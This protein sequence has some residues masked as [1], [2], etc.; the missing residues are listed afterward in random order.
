[1]KLTGPMTVR[2]KGPLKEKLT[3]PMTV[4]KKGPLKEKLMV[5]IPQ[6]T[7]IHS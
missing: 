4:R 5:Q 1:V 7:T 6:E 3:G 2:K